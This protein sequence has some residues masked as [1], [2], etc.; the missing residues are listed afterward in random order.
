MSFKYVNKKIKS[1]RAMNNGRKYRSLGLETILR[2][3]SRLA[4]TVDGAGS[5]RGPWPWKAERTQEGKE[6]AAPEPPAV[7]VRVQGPAVW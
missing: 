2:R 5:S 1:Y 7:V 4:N 3:P 6:A